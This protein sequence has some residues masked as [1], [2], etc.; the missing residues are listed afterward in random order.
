MTGQSFQGFHNC[1]QRE[2]RRQPTVSKLL[3][4]AVYCN[5]GLP[6]SSSKHASSLNIPRPWT[7]APLPM[8]KHFIR[9]RCKLNVLTWSELEFAAP[10]ATVTPP[11]KAHSEREGART[12]LAP[13]SNRVASASLPAGEAATLFPERLDPRPSMPCHD[14]EHSISRNPQ[15]TWLATACLN[16]D[17]NERM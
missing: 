13:M 7:A 2:I 12:C 10:H 16:T 11:I 4:L 6:V 5:R 1:R 9:L 15:C 8:A 14:Q 17:A 3:H